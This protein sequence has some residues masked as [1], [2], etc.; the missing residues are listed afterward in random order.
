MSERIVKI[1]IALSLFCLIASA[2]FYVSS[3]SDDVVTDP[4]PLAAAEKSKPQKIRSSRSF[5]G[6]FSLPERTEDAQPASA[7]DTAWEEGTL[8]EDEGYVSETE[9]IISGSVFL[10]KNG[11]T[12]DEVTVFLVQVKAYEVET[13]D[14]ADA[15]GGELSE[16][17]TGE[18]EE[19]PDPLD[20]KLQ[21]AEDMS[22][23]VAEADAEVE[24]A[25][26][27]S[28]EEPEE[29][30]VEP[31]YHD[32][33]Y[34]DENGGFEEYVAPGE[35]K[36]IARAA[37]H[38][39]VAVEGIIVNAREEVRGIVLEL[40]EGYE[41]AGVVKADEPISEGVEVV[42]EGEGYRQTRYADA[43][44]AFAFDSLPKGNFKISAFD[45]VAGKAEVTARAGE[46][47][48]SLRLAFH[49]LT[50][51]VFDEQGLPVEGIE[52]VGRSAYLMAQ[53]SDKDPH[54]TVDGM[55][56]LPPEELSSVEEQYAVTDE[57]G[58]F[59]LKMASDGKVT[60]TA[61]G[62][63][64]DTAVLKDV[65][66]TSRGVQLRL[67]KGIEVKLR[68]SQ[69]PQELGEVW[70]DIEPESDD[71]GMFHSQS[72]STGEGEVSFFVSPDVKWIIQ[73]DG[74]GRVEPA[75][76]LPPN[77]KMGK[78]FVPKPRNK[79]IVLWHDADEAQVVNDGW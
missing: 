2:V 10:R 12:F 49:E 41:I 67:S 60:L 64:G 74:R 69:V 59:A 39:T 72:T 42:L 71:S 52:V 62:Y 24:D 27:T 26:E 65:D 7:V 44:G 30:Y 76:P 57:S 54:G 48:V 34:L 15:E 3:S 16:E 8:A 47:T 1:A 9:G 5:S 29:A 33:I 32:P 75:G 11:M 21:R 14:E 17:V 68:V 38:Q 56:E 46:T 4:A 22:D 25:E 6:D 40:E 37:G 35:Y 70:I 19:A 63:E 23:A 51:T 61:Q 66:P 73:Y 31:E 77:V 36:L 55:P 58:R 13:P 53:A 50:G 28:E 18:S 45:P 43:D 78:P 79:K 20:P